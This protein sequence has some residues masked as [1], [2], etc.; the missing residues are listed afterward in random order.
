MIERKKIVWLFALLCCWFNPAQAQINTERVLTIGRNALYFEDYV[1]SIQYFNS[2]IRSKPYLA[3]PYLYRAMAKLNLE[4]FKGAED[5]LTRSIEINPFIVHSYLYR[6]VARQ[7]QSDYDGAIEDYN[8]GLEFRPEDRQFLINKGIAHVQNKDFDSA[9]ATLD[10]LIKY[11]P[12]FAQAYLTRGSVYAEKGDTIEALNDFNKSLEL[13]KYFASAYAQRGILY[14]QQENYQDA[15]SDYNEALR[16]EPKQIGFYINRG[17]IKYSLDEYRGA[18]ADFDT[19]TILDPRNTIGRFNRGLLRAQVGDLSRAVEDFDIVISN[20]PDNFMAIYNRAILHEELRNYRD[21]ITDID[22]VLKEYPYFVIGYYFR[23]GIKRAMNDLK[24]ADSDYWYAYDL[25]Q[26]LRQEKEKG[27]TVTGKGVF[28]PSDLPEK[29]TETDEKNTRERSDKN[30]E[31]FNRLVVYDK[32]EEIKSSYKNEIRG[33]VQDRQIKVDLASQ[34]VITYY[35]RPDEIDK[36][37]T[38]F[39]KTISDYNAKNILN[40]QLKAINRETA[41]SGQQVD[42]HF[43]SIDDYSL[44]I[45]KNPNNADAYFGRALDYM[46]LQDLSEALND[47]TR[48]IELRP[49]FIMAYFNRAVIRFK[50]MQTENFEENVTGNDMQNLS[51]NIQ[52]RPNRPVLSTTIPSTQPRIDINNSRKIEEGRRAFEF[53]QII[54]DYNKI[55]QI[56][57]DFVLAYYNRANINCFQQDFRQAL[58]NYTEAID[59]NPDFAEAYYNRGLTRLYSGDIKG[60]IADLSKAG[61]L[62]I[63]EAYSIMKKM[64]SE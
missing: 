44:A 23:S 47:F 42:F 4:D 6:G 5:D 25:E 8:K 55:I 24:G 40:M 62:G 36:T 14:Y 28:N 53:E 41:I 52:T 38:R 22:A 12:K 18:M 54:Q 1:L 7:Y 56:N 19:V 31:K 43:N 57:P 32:E 60:G 37:I 17:L 29:T 50:L 45:D 35:E 49:D 13:D 30:I 10:R 15:L 34:F 48:A 51:F 11:Q 63:A 16:L 20:E 59:R 21:A 27:M 39:D 3:E 61:E 46:V 9:I 64:A 2:V 26:K 33:R 58:I